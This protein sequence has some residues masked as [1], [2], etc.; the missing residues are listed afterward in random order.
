MADLTLRNVKGSPLTNQEVDD[1]FSNL[2]TDKW[3]QDNTKISN[4]DTAYSW[5][6]HAAVGYLT[7]IPS[8]YLTETEGDAR[9]LNINAT[10]L[11]DQTGH[12]G[13]FLTT[14]GTT[15]DWATV[16]TSL[17]DTAYGWGNHASVGYLPSSSYTAADVLTKV[18]TVDG[19]GSG[20]DADSLD[21]Q[22]GSYYY[23]A[24]NP[25][26]YTDDQTASEIL[27]AVKTVDGSGS[28][29][30]ADLLDGID[31]T[32]FTKAR[33]ASNW[34]DGTVINNVVGLLS[35][36]NYGNGHVIF[37]ASSGISPAGSAVNNTNS[38]GAWT[39][40]YP[41]LMGWNG[42]ATYG[43]RVD[44]ARIADSANALSGISAS[45]FVQQGGAYYTVGNTAAFSGANDTTL[46]VRSNGPAAAT[47]SFHRPGQF[48]ANFGLDTD[49]QLKY[50]GWSAG[51][52][53]PVMHDGVSGG[54][55]SNA[56]NGGGVNY[57]Y[58][59][60][61]VSYAPTR[62]SCGNHVYQCWGGALT[63]TLN[64]ASWQRG[65]IV[66]LSNVSGAANI[67]VNAYTIYMPNGASD[68]QVT[69]NATV[70]SFRLCKYST[71][72]GYWMVLP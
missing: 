72:V 69:W 7:S 53:H 17:G 62:G 51:D 41:T 38:A 15:A 63:L 43:V 35:W 14:N 18:K 61:T 16:D 40:S 42:S 24:S 48:A 50:G 11:P 1:N 46:S 33:G 58:V 28:G 65:D 25:N 36:K 2:N 71:T 49:N 19:A 47:M 9:Y 6:D 26:G 55:I 29:L 20:L 68:N 66:V 22:Q 12:A 39:A 3:S 57:V 13:Q 70:G 45:S 56:T 27:T 59:D 34:N 54:T 30:D 8:E 44:S 60:G 21:G 10:T 31:S 37:D 32:G 5:G 52:V 67:V 23:P 64:D 4:W